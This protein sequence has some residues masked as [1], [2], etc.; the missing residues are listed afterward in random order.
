MKKIRKSLK[1]LIKIII[2]Q[3]WNIA[4]A[5]LI[6]LVIFLGSAIVGIVKTTIILGGV[7][8]LV[9]AIRFVNIVIK[10]KKKKKEKKEPTDKKPKKK[11]KRR[12]NLIILIIL[13]AGIISVLGGIVFLGYVVASAPK[14]DAKIYI[15]KKLVFS[16]IK[17]IMKF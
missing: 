6:F 17:T 14:F 11:W 4:I 13:W 7:V 3:G 12:L 10:K 8:L 1:K 9:A 5:I 16:M 2:K 15:I